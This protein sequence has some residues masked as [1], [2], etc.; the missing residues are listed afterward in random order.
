MFALFGI[1]ILFVGTVVATLEY[2][3]VYSVTAFRMAAW[4]VA[5]S[6]A[7]RKEIAEK[8]HIENVEAE[9]NAAP[10][11]QGKFKGADIFIG[12]LQILLIVGLLAGVV[13][14]ASLLL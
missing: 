13:G 11:E 4:G 5:L 10:L 3:A 6:L 2:C 7:K 8:K 12:I 14:V 9:L 1:G